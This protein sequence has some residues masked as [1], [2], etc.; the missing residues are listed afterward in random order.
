[1]TFVRVADM[2]SSIQ[3]EG[4]LI[5]TPSHFIRFA[6]CNLNCVWC[7]TEYAQG[8]VGDKQQPCLLAEGLWSIMLSKGIRHFVITGGEPLLYPDAIVEI[9]KEFWGRTDYVTPQAHFTIETNG[10]LLPGS[11]TGFFDLWSI[12]PKL[13]NAEVNYP[14]WKF[15]R[16]VA[17]LGSSLGPSR[18]QFKLVVD[19]LDDLRQPDIKKFLKATRDYHKKGVPLI[20][21]PNGYIWRRDRQ[22][23]LDLMTA[24]AQGAIK[25]HALSRNFDI[26]V[27]P[28]LHVLLDID[29][30]AD[31]KEAPGCTTQ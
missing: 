21:Q 20:L 8:L 27:L 19:S 23:Y 29:N 24:L 18:V 10:T 14:W 31:D 11:T 30:Y 5:G 16:V 15:E 17:A 13:E 6:G 25:K 3:G 1:M 2:V 22:T 9:V 28:Q 4:R 7:D 26:Q 12:S